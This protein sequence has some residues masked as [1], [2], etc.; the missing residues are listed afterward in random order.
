[1]TKD[2]R[3][4]SLSVQDVTI[5]YRVVRPIALLDI[6]RKKSKG[7]RKGKYF[8]AVKGVSFEIDRGEIV[9]MIGK[10]G[11]GKSTLLRAIANIYS[12]DTGSIDVHGNSV[13]LMAIGVGFVNDLSG[14][15]NVYL[16]GMLMGFT[17]QQIE[18]K[19]NEIIDFSELE[20][21]IDEPVRSYSS[22]MHSKLAFSITAIM[23]TDIM[24]VDETLSVGDRRF[25][26]K[27]AEKMQSLIVSKD[28]TVLIVSHTTN[29]LRELCER[30]IWLDGG[31]I[32]MDGE[33]N[34]VLDAYEEA[35]DKAGK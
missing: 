18:E 33:A 25:K 11:S 16:S 10:N 2:T 4:I 34:E 9:G 23:E 29:T 21:F 26:K 15:D 13:G 14:R 31:K 28:K 12:P 22:G 5:A 1:M 8:K 24:L 35:I 6:F 20:E 19:M 32:R 27:S 7:K 3:E 30:V 17:K